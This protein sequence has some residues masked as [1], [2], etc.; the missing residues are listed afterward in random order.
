M[1]FFSPEEYLTILV[2]LVPESSF[3]IARAARNQ[4][5]ARYGK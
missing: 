2:R 5:V 4:E 1:P 3:E